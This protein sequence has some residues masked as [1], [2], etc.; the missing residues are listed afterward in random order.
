[1]YINKKLKIILESKSD[2]PEDDFLNNLLQRQDEIVTHSEQIFK[3]QKLIIESIELS[4]RLTNDLGFNNHLLKMVFNSKA[5]IWGDFDSKFN[6]VI[7]KIHKF[8]MNFKL[9]LIHTHVNTFSQKQKIAIELSFSRHAPLSNKEWCQ[10][11]LNH[12]DFPNHPN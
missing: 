7:D 2:M 9:N 3:D 6:S 10:S 11:D 5:H 12:I 1:M 8:I 4:N